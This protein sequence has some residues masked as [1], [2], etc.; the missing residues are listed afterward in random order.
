M[1]LPNIP[2]ITPDISLSRCKTID[3]LLASIA[4]EEIG[5]SHILNAEGEKLQAFLETG[6]D[7][8]DDFLLINE[9][10]NK[11]LRTVVKSQM[12]LNMKLDEVSSLDEDG[13]KCESEPKEEPDEESDDHH[14]CHDRCK[15][16]KGC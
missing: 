9:S 12:L 5:L 13:C 15:G 3:L 7:S 14:Y 4:L 1:S 10:I 2:N 16:C 6:P 11:T 8:L